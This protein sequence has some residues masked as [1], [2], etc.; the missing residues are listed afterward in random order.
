MGLFVAEGVDR[1]EEGGFCCGDEAEDDAGGGGDAEA[2]GDGPPGDDDIDH[3]RVEARERTESVAEGDAQAAADDA[4]GHGFGKEL[5]QDITTAGA[6]GFSE[7][8]FASA[9]GDADEHDVHDANPANEERDADDAREDDCSDK[10]HFI[11]GLED[12]V[13][14]E[15]VEVVG[16]IGGEGVAAAEE[17]DDLGAG[18]GDGFFGD[19]LGG[20]G[21]FSTRG[22]VNFEGHGVGDEHEIVLAVAKEA[23]FFLEDADDAEA[24]ALEEE[25]VADDVFVE[26]ELAK[27]FAA[28]DADLMGAFDVDHGEGAADVDGKISDGVVFGGAAFNGDGDL[29]AAVAELGGLADDERGDACERWASALDGFDVVFVELDAAEAFAGLTGG[30]FGPDPHGVGAEALEELGDVGGE[31]LDDADDGDSGGDGDDDA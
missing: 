16:L 29:F 7:A 2:E 12:F 30:T 25:E 23:A 3:L 10:A 22:G 18:F 20:D 5:E 13:L 28:D 21:H 19:S 15:D 11:E 26:V 27:D 4:E 6:D 14:G 9:L 24:A 8:D 17:V 1:V 31:A